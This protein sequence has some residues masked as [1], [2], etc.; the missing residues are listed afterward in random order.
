MQPRTSL[1]KLAG[2]S[3]DL[4]IR[5]LAEVAP[6]VL[7]SDGPMYRLWHKTDNTFSSPRVYVLAHAHTPAYE[8]GPETVTMMRLFCNV[9]NDDL[10]SFAYDARIAG[11]SYSL[12]YSDSRL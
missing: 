1:S 6:P 2:D 12:K 8:L 10:N 9:V 11:L 4:C 7:L 3:I 5:L